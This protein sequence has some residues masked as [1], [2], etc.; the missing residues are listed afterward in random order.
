M[1]IKGLMKLVSQATCNKDDFG[2]GLIC[3]N[4]YG[5]VFKQYG[6]KER[7]ITSIGSSKLCSLGAY[8]NLYKKFK[9]IRRIHTIED[10]NHLSEYNRKYDLFFAG[11]I[12]T[13]F[14]SLELGSEET[15]FDV[16]VF[17]K[18]PNNKFFPITFYYGPSGASIGAWN[19]VFIKN[20]YDIIL[21]QTIFPNEFLSVINFSPFDFSKIELNLFIEAFLCAISKIPI[22]DF[23]AYY[24]SDSVNFQVGIRLGE[25]YI[26]EASDHIL[27]RTWSYSI[28]GSDDAMHLYHKYVSIINESLTP[29]EL[30]KRE[31]LNEKDKVD[32]ILIERNYEQLLKFA[33]NQKTRLAF[34]VLGE[35][36]MSHGGLLSEELR[37]TILKYSDWSYEKFQFKSK[38]DRT[39]RKKFLDDFREKVQNYDGSEKIFLPFYTVSRVIKEMEA[40]GDDKSNL[41]LES[42]D[43]SIDEQ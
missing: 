36:I 26:I 23:D 28:L 33:C 29:K 41:W 22:S 10:L 42:I 13:L 24:R 12:M 38:T 30:E 14:P 15:L 7:Y 27:S 5:F 19:S 6:S 18:T 17:V 20:N 8:K 1:S 40:R 4:G 2:N 16:W 31:D 37:H 9:N 35:F 34:I 11:A 43:Y 21:N 25:P 32:K 39:E 3:C